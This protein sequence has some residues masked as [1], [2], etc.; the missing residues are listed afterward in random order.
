MKDLTKGKTLPLIM[1]FAIPIAI[2][3]IFQLF[4]S[5]ADTRIVGQFLGE[6][7]LASVGATS[8]LNNMIIGFL[9][10]MTNGFAIIVARSYGAKD[11]KAIKK[12]VAATF[13]LGIAVS[14]VFTVLSVGFLRNILEFLNTPKNLIDGAYRYFRIILLGMSGAM[15]YNVC[16]GLFRAIGQK[17][18]TPTMGGVIIL[19]AILVPILLFGR[20]DNIYIQLMIVSTVWLGLIGGL[21]DYIKVFRHNKEGLKGRFKIVGQ[22]GLGII[23][24]T[25][26]C[27]VA[28]DRRPREGHA[29]RADRLH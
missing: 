5:L 15:L 4:Y 20:L 23:V 26:M 11:E 6:N 19:L 10:G 13:V 24:G 16:A 9:L 21:D 25:T 14:L 28:R 17:R 3:N 29:A 1:G 7:A 8:S 27:A 18:G 12:A 2:G 22:V